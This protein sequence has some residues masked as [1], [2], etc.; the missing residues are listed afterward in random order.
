MAQQTYQLEPY[1][2]ERFIPSHVD[3]IVK[4]VVDEIAS[5]LENNSEADLDQVCHDLTEK[6]KMAVVMQGNLPRHRI[7][8]Q[9]FVSRDEGQSLFVASKSLWDASVDNYTC[10]TRTLTNK[11]VLTVIVFCVYKE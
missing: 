8:V 11:I 7:A 10:V 3:N 4:T 6:A 9:S 5:E 2:E 1:V